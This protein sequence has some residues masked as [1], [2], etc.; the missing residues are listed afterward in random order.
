MGVC[1]VVRVFGMGLREGGSYTFTQY[2]DDDEVV[3]NNDVNNNPGHDLMLEWEV[4]LRL[5]AA[6][7][8]QTF[9]A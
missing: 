3:D 8:I 6:G 2:R 7:L 5:N 1:D 9:Q 4:L